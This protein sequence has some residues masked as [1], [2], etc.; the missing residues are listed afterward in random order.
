[1]EGE[2]TVL[3]GFE[4]GRLLLRPRTMADFDACLAMDRD[5]VVAQF[6]PGPWH[7][8]GQHESFLRERIGASFGDGLGYWSIFP[9]EHPGRFLGWILLIP[10]DGIGPEVEIGWRLDRSAR[11]NGFA[12]E[13]ARPV[14]DHAFRTLGLDCIIADIHAGNLASLRVAERIGMEYIGDGRGEH[15][16]RR[17]AMRRRRGPESATRAKQ[18]SETTAAPAGERRR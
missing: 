7:E 18:K 2:T 12:A 14:A 9:K 15:P 4:T 8:P 11:G 1:M 5:P 16:C 10:R 13:A 3:P 17:Y 6:I